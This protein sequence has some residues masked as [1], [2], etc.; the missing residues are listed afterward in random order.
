MRTD[1][2]VPESSISLPGPRDSRWR[3]IL[4]LCPG[5]WIE[6]DSGSLPGPRDSGQRRRSVEVLCFRS[7]GPDRP[8]P[9]SDA[10]SAAAHNKDFSHN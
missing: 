10:T 8:A 4:D 1:I 7:S 3:Q 2:Y 5:L 9:P 6:A